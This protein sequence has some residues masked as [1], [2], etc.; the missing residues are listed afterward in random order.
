MTGPQILLIS[1]SL[2]EK[3]SNSAAIHTVAAQLRTKADVV[4]YGEMGVLPHFNPDVEAKTLPEVVARLR[5]SI[6]DS[7]AVMICT[8]EYAGALPGSFK[9]LLDWTVGG[10]ETVG[11]PAAWINV[12]AHATKAEGAHASLRIVL[13]YTGADIVEEACRHVPLAA[14]DLSADGLV[15]TQ[16]AIEQLGSAAFT[17]LERARL[18][19]S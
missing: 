4:I 12:S 15:K 9:N 10:M 3:S 2:R 16:A 8:P 11:K 5:K 7:S 14:A 18:G 1:G 19:S 13:A 17:L 6:E